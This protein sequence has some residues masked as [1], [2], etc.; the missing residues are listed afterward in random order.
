MGR[1]RLPPPA[2]RWP[3]SSG[4][5][6]TLLCMRSRMT[7]L[8]PFM[9]AATRLIIA[10]SDGSRLECSGWTVAV[11]PSALA[12]GARLA[13]GVEPRTSRKQRALISQRNSGPV[14]LD[15]HVDHLAARLDGHEHA[16]AAVFCG[17]LDQIADHLVEVLALD[18]HLRLAVPGDVDGDVLVQ[19]VERAL[20]GLEA[21]PHQ[22]ARLGR[23]PAADGARPGEVVVDLAAHHRRLPAHGV[24]EV[25]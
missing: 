5:S 6:A 8:T 22:R 7:A 19:P 15:Q 16:A 18:P 10:A 4:I 24:R 1:M 20:D 17:I 13:G 11:M 3:A 25:G 9:S 21:L 12:A 14:V 2:I 23:C